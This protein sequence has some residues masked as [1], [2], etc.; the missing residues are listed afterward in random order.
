VDT[1]IR[2][3]SDPDGPDCFSS[4]FVTKK[5]S[6]ELLA[7]IEAL[8][9][10]SWR[11]ISDFTPEDALKAEELRVEM[12]AFIQEPSFRLGK[13]FTRTL[14]ALE[15]LGRAYPPCCPDTFMFTIVG[16]CFNSDSCCRPVGVDARYSSFVNSC[17]EKYDEGD[18]LMGRDPDNESFD[19]EVRNFERPIRA[20]WNANFQVG[21]LF[22]LFDLYYQ[23]FL[24]CDDDAYTDNYKYE[25]LTDPDYY[26][27]ILLPDLVAPEDQLPGHKYVKCYNDVKYL[28]DMTHDDRVIAVTAM[29]CSSLVPPGY[30]VRLFYDDKKRLVLGSHIVY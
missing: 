20:D 24:K 9:V 11:N 8:K 2:F 21:L 28:A 27:Q 10:R 29:P 13:K 17:F 23:K 19:R 7:R 16:S 18:I 6:T 14:C 25:V 4:A 15:E 3:V 1:Y 26:V 30:G 12:L 22:D 5:M